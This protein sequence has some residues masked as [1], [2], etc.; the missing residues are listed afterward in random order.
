MTWTIELTRAAEKAVTAL[1]PK[2]RERVVLALSE[3]AV[4]PFGARNVKALVD[5]RGY[6]LRI[7][8]YR[9]LYV[10]DAASRTVTV[11]AVGQR[12]RFYD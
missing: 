5:R 11:E 2:A 3:L 1:P 9:A 7:G 4:D 6:R 10:V 8:D 12:G